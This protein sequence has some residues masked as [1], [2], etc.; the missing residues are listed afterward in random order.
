MIP[1]LLRLALHWIPVTPSKRVA[2]PSL[3]VALV[4]L[5]I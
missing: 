5:V 2:K 3:S 4:W 1:S